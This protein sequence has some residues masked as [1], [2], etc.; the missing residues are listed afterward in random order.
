MS[1]GASRVG[2]GDGSDAYFD[3]YVDDDDG[4]E[5]D[6]EDD[7]GSQADDYDAGDGDGKSFRVR[8]GEAYWCIAGSVHLLERCSKLCSNAMHLR[9]R[10]CSRSR[11]LCWCSARSFRKLA[12][13]LYA[14]RNSFCFSRIALFFCEA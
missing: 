11:R 14:S 1:R 8:G 7:N 13:K 6:E 10:T 2:T 4:D 9:K 5:D 12:C 3:D